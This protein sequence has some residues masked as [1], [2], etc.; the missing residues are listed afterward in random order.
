[1]SSWQEDDYANNFLL[2]SLELNLFIFFSKQFTPDRK[3]LMMRT[4]GVDVSHWEGSINWKLAAPTIGFAYYKCT[5]GVRYVDQ[6][7]HANRQGCS[8]AGLAH[9]PYHFYQPAL[10]PLTQAEFFIRTAGK[11]YQRYIVDLETPE[12]QEDLP[13]RLLAFLQ[14]VEQLTGIKP[15]I[16]TSPGYWNDFVWPHPTWATEYELIVAHYT[17]AHAPILPIDWKD[18]RI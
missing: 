6:Q 2:S 15:A 12:R 1:M 17:L 3:D 11:A 5:D 8:A 13:Q 14:K 4:L 10:D 18:W 9:A 16:Y 7:F